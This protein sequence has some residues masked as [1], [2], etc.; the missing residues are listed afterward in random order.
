M[1]DGLDDGN[2]Y[3]LALIVVIAVFAWVVAVVG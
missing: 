2:L 3:A 1:N